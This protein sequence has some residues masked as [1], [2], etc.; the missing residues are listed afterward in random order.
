MSQNYQQCHMLG[1]FQAEMFI[2]VVQSPHRYDKAETVVCCAA[3]LESCLESFM[4]I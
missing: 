1:C 3:R 2:H 4:M